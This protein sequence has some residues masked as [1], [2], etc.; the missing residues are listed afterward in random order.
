[1]RSPIR[2]RCPTRP[3]SRGNAPVPIV[4]WVC[5]VLVGVVPTVA[6]V[7]HA[8][9]GMSERRYGQS[10][11]QR[12]RTFIPA[13]SHTI[14]TMSRGGT[15]FSASASRIDSPSGARK[16]KPRSLAWVGAMSASVTGRSTSPTGAMCPGP[17]QNIGIRW[18]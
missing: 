7:Y 2:M 16:G 12:S 4:A 6:F 14:V 17:Y 1:M 15:A 8:P 5:A 13:A 18:A 3:C 11:G 10:S 9:S